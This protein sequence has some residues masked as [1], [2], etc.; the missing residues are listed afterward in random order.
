MMNEDTEVPYRARRGDVFAFRP[1]ASHPLTAVFLGMCLGLLAIVL[2]GCEEIRIES[3]PT[4]ATD[5]DYVHPCD[6]PHCVREMAGWIV[7]YLDIPE[8]YRIRNY[9]GGSCVHASMETVMHWQGMHEIADWWRA[10]YSYGE[11]S[12]RMH[13]RLDA[14]GLTFAAVESTGPDGWEFLRKCCALRLGCAINIPNGHMQTLVGMD[15]TSVYIIDNNG[16]GEVYSMPLE[17]FAQGWTGWA[18]TVIGNPP[19]PEPFL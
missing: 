7:P 6:G 2:S 15:E 10:T 3:T 8:P 18:V 5:L 13:S 12:D 11:Y 19:P 16:P 1:R 14:A 9:D 17:R 4:P